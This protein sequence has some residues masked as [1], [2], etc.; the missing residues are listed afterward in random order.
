MSKY[1]TS[2][3]FLIISKS[4]THRDMDKS[5][6]LIFTVVYM[7]VLLHIKVCS[8]YFSHLVSLFMRHIS[9]FFLRL[10]MLMFLQ[11]RP[12]GG[13]KQERDENSGACRGQNVK[14]LVVKIEISEQNAK[15]TWSSVH[16]HHLSNPEIR[17]NHPLLDWAESLSKID[18]PEFDSCDEV[19]GSSRRPNIS[20]RNGSSRRRR[21]EELG[22][23]SDLRPFRVPGDPRL[24]PF[25]TT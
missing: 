25:S 7:F 11:R 17:L 21:P 20:L 12:I 14:F 9:D 23:A 18:G 1:F 13:R 19:P 2:N 3:I 5:Y 4:F 16:H 6:F 15:I 10:P 22:P 24:F 8:T